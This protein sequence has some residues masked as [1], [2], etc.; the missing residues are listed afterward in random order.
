MVAA[1]RAPEATTY[2]GGYPSTDRRAS[3]LACR[4]ED[5][6]VAGGDK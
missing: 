3:A 4:Q 2:A 1:D 5:A 6:C